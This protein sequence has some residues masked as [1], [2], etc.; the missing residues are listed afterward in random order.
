MRLPEDRT[1]ERAHSELATLLQQPSA[2]SVSLSL[3]VM[4]TTS[5]LV[6]YDSASPYV[7][8]FKPH[9]AARDKCEQEFAERWTSPASRLPE[10]LALEILKHVDSAASVCA[11]ASVSREWHDLT[12]LDEDAVWTCVLRSTFGVDMAQMNSLSA[13]NRKM[14]KAAAA[15]PTSRAPPHAASAAPKNFKPAVH[16]KPLALFKYVHSA[17][18][19]IR[20]QMLHEHCAQASRKALRASLAFGGHRFGAAAGAV[21]PG[22]EVPIAPEPVTAAAQ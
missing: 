9:R 20:K 1:A 13:S 14:A 18:G 6:I 3:F 15:T 8:L 10:E 16:R 19:S 22:M 17:W 2:L 12:K 11:A 7:R 5:Q 4:D 21:L